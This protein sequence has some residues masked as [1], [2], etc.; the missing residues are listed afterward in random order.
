MPGVFLTPVAGVLS[1]KFGR[2][3][4][5]IPSLL[6]FGVAGG[7]CALVSEFELLFGLRL[8]QG[9]GAA[10]LGATTKVTLIGDLFVGREWTAALGYNSCVLSTGTRATRR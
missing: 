4:V 8:L 7:A 5:L 6:L 10:A 2:K 9:V 1:Y 3:T